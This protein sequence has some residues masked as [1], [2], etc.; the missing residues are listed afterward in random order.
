VTYRNDERTLT[1]DEV[2]A[3]HDRI[4]QTLERSFSAQLR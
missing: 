3:M 2:N 4:R 1:D